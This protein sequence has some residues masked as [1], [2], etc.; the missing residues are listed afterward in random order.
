MF[1]HFQ[2]KGVYITESVWSKHELN[3]PSDYTGNGKSEFTACFADG[4]SVPGKHTSLKAV[5]AA[6]TRAINARI[7]QTP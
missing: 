2:Y 4:V 3:K 6:V 7:A 5:K 1:A